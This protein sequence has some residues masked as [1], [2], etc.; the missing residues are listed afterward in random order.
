MSEK[1]KIIN[2]YKKKIN[3]LK[4]H[5]KL[6]FDKDNPKI[7]DSEYDNLKKEILEFE[8][9]NNF[10]LKLNLN[11]TIGTSPSKK[12]KKIKHLKPMLSLSNAFD[13]NDMKDFVSKITNFI[14]KILHIIF[15]KS[16]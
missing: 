8:K 4:K 10:L 14:N 15:I 7:S 12:F 13:Q 3:L 5:N 9:K 11:K 6:Y 2:N 16:I 1:L